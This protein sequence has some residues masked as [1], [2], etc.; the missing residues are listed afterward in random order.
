MKQMSVGVNTAP[1]VELKLAEIQAEAWIGGYRTI[2]FHLYSG[3]TDKEI[4]VQIAQAVRSQFPDSVIAGTL[5]AGEIKDGKLMD[6]GI[7]ISALLF[8]ET[9]VHLQRYADAKGHEKEIGK[10]IREYSMSLPDIKA[11]ELVMPGS[12]L[13]T[14]AMYEELGKAREDIQ[15][16]G[17][18]SGGHELTCPLHFVFNDEGIFEDH[19]LALFYAGPSFYIDTAKSVGWQTLGRPFKI[20]KA[21]GNRLIEIEGAPAVEVYEKYLRISRYE[22]FAEDTFEF[23]L[24]ALT[25]GDELLRHTI[26]VDEEGA[27]ILA[28]YATEGM[29]VILSYGNPSLIVEKVDQRL[30]E[31]R[32][33][34]PEAILLYS[35]S[36]R[37]AFWENFVNIEM[38][39]FQKI[40][41]TAGF[42]TWGE[43]MRN[44]QNGKVMENNIT[45]VSIAMR[46]GPAKGLPVPEVKVDDS[47]LR[48]Q[49]SLIKRLS[50]LV[51]ATT[52]ELQ[53]AYQ[54]MRE[55]NTMLRDMSEHDAL[56][57][58]YNRGKIEKMILDALDRSCATGKPISL[59][60]ADIDHFKRV[61][62]TYGHAAGDGVLRTVA[63]ILEEQ[64]GQVPG[65]AAGR[66]G[67]EEF[68]LLLPDTQETGA[69][70]LAEALRQKIADTAFPEA[71]KMTVSIGVITSTGK[72]DRKQLF[73]HVDEMLYVAK[74][75]GRNRVVQYHA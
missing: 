68:F 34:Q 27:L 57:H 41:P 28:G 55:M 48:G 6:T 4:L 39:P 66:W 5:S 72:E 31:A 8:K 26:T 62:D 11:V 44:R 1:E 63:R 17:G 13:D 25:E 61:N 37:K 20:T 73:T 42:H 51:S 43:V 52:S 75:S 9:D 23:P 71:G 22:G 12:E 35:C 67:G 18:Y 38:E 32:L 64:A 36:V 69:A 74:E 46:E 53:N 40:A 54:E 2:V 49:A 30:E 56:T 58:L 21:D 70:Q 3:S 47:V 16:F 10:M 59:L 60:M 50:Q 45:L 14:F 15:Y 65:G 24:I 29:D 19:V 7:L 33:F